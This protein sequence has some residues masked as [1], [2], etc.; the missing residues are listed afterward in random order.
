MCNNASVR[1]DPAARTG[2]DQ[3]LQQHFSIVCPFRM[4]TL[5]RRDVL[6]IVPTLLHQGCQDSQLLLSFLSIVPPGINSECHQDTDDDKDAFKDEFAWFGGH[7]G[8]I[9]EGGEVVKL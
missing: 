3:L 2:F 7:G 4:K 8:S 1:G 9:G 5:V 6:S